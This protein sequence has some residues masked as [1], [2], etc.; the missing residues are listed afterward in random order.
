VFPQVLGESGEERLLDGLPDVDLR[1]I[2]SQV[3]DQRLVLLD[4]RLPTDSVV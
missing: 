1:L 3:L 4:Y 2:S